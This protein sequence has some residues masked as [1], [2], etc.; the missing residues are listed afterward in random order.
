M[1]FKGKENIWLK[2]SG[3]KASRGKTEFEVQKGKFSEKFKKREKDTLSV[4]SSRPLSSMRVGKMISGRL[5]KRKERENGVLF[6]SGKGKKQCH[7]AVMTGY[8]QRPFPPSPG[9]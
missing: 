8:L 9:V 6:R 7:H 4:I 5:Q 1:N 2:S 3:L